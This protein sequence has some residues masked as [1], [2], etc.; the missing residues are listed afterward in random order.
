LFCGLPQALFVLADKEGVLFLLMF[1]EIDYFV[2][3]SEFA[4]EF[5]NASF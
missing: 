3:F 2:G 4:L 5:T 1:V